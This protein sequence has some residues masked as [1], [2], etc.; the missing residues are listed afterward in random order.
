MKEETKTELLKIAADLTVAAIQHQAG[1]G[2]A[3]QNKDIKDAFQKSVVLV[4]EQFD[5]LDKPV[6]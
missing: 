4:A 5:S 1:F 2:K 6:A 3:L